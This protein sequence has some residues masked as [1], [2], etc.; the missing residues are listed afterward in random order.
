MICPNCKAEIADDAKFCTSCGTAVSQ[1]NVQTQ[2]SGFGYENKTLDASQDDVTAGAAPS[3]PVQSYER[4][5][6]Q[7]AQPTQP[8][9][10]QQYQPPQYQS[11]PQP[12]QYQYQP[13]PQPQQNKGSKTPL[14][15]VIIVLAVLLVGGGITAA[16]IIANSMNNNNNNNNGNNNNYS[17]TVSDNSTLF[18]SSDYYDSSEDDSSYY[19]SS[20]EEYSSEPESS[21]VES[22]DS[23]EL[24]LDNIKKYRGLVKDFFTRNTDKVISD[25]SDADLGDT[26]ELIDIYYIHRDASGFTRIVYVYYNATQKYYKQ[27]LCAPDSYRIYQESKIIGRSGLSED[28]AYFSSYT[29]TTSLTEVT[30]TSWLDASFYDVT[31]I[32]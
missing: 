24:T 3:Q 15:I 7:S 26:I 5:Q 17:Q 4:P 22:S 20:E 23:Q 14:I 31:K 6:A 27:A 2:T 28:Y 13:Q 11:Q 19:Y 1:E 9:Q 29:K 8:V 18:E 32:S 21:S 10:P 16:I 12:Q 25:D 30:T